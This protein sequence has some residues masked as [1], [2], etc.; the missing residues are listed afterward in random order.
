MEGRAIA[1]PN[2]RGLSFNGGPGNCPAV[3]AGNALS[4]WPTEASMEGR[5][6]ARPNSLMQSLA[7]DHGRASALQWRAG[8]LPGQTRAADQKRSER[9]GEASMEGRAIARPNVAVTEAITVVTILPASMEGRAI[10]R[11]NAPASPLAASLEGRSADGT[12]LSFN[13]GPGNCPAKHEMSETGPSPRAGRPACFNGGPGNCPAKPNG[14]RGPSAG[15]L[16]LTLQWRAGQLPGQTRRRRYRAA[17]CTRLRFNG[18]PGNCPAKRSAMIGLR[19]SGVMAASME[20]RAIARPNRAIFASI[21][22]DIGS[23]ASME[24]RAIARPNDAATTELGHQPSA[25]VLQWRAGQLP[26]QTGV[27]CPYGRL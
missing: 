2:L 20:G 18:G 19:Y 4:D 7:V 25:A 12:D 21:G 1:R 13:G 27:R 26:G 24:G 15:G 16:T 3:A 6:I 9:F 14:V 23:A 22:R 11:P 17:G 5:A 10:A 8:Q